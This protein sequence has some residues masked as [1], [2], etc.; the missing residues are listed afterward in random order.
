M[1]NNRHNATAVLRIIDNRRPFEEGFST[2]SPTDQFFW[3]HEAILTAKSQ[4]FR[5][6]FGA[7]PPPPPPRL[8]SLRSSSSGGE[9]RAPAHSAISDRFN[10]GDPQPITRAWNGIVFQWQGIRTSEQNVSEP[11]VV[12]YPRTADRLPCRRPLGVAKPTHCN[13]TC[14]VTTKS[15][16]PGSIRV[17]RPST[18]WPVP[19]ITVC[20]PHTVLFPN[21]LRWLYTGDDRQFNC[22]LLRLPPDEVNAALSVLEH[23]GVGVG[24]GRKRQ[25]SEQDGTPPS[26]GPAAPPAAEGPDCGFARQRE[27]GGVYSKPKRVMEATVFPLPVSPLAEKQ[28]PARHF[29]RRP[30][31]PA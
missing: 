30:M 16:R 7:R 20:L 23:L 2:V 4:L 13:N 3:V 19:M 6:A 5:Q 27:E 17:P 18:T 29:E 15:P 14:A 8:P 21:A 28:R 10:A 31:V 12:A 24:I 22:S 11:V 9:T 1:F 26:A 25:R